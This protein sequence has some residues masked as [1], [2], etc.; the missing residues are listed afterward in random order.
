MN[1][2]LLK[3][4]KT[5]WFICSIP[6]LVLLSQAFFISPKVSQFWS[7]SLAISGFTAVSLLVLSLTFAP[8]TKHFPSSNLFSILRRHKREVGLSAFYYVLIHVF[9]Y[10]V[11]KYIKTGTFPWEILLRPFIL[12]GVTAFLILIAMAL[13]SNKWSIETLQKHRW[14]TLHRFVYLAE[15][16]VFTH[17]ALQGGIV[18]LWGLVLFIPLLAI[19][20]IRRSKKSV[21]TQG[22]K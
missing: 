3:Q 18:L 12:A 10:V 14:K 15:A 1:L 4:K 19:Q 9:S 5:I 6:L 2:S 20:L 22:F 21:N 17:M 8:L 16:A 13:T 7:R 11:K